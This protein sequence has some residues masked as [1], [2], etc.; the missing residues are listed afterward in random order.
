LA[1][2]VGRE[3]AA[4][5]AG[6]SLRRHRRRLYHST[7]FASCGALRREKD[8]REALRFPALQ[9]R[10]CFYALRS[11]LRSWRE[12]DGPGEH[13]V[14]APPSQRRSQTGSQK[15]NQRRCLRFF[16]PQ[17]LEITK[18]FPDSS[19]LC[20]LDVS[21]RRLDG[22]RIESR[23]S[24]PAAVARRSGHV[25]SRTRTQTTH[26]ASNGPKP[27]GDTI[28]S[29][30]SSKRTRQR[31][32]LDSNVGPHKCTFSFHRIHFPALRRT[33]HMRTNVRA[34]LATHKKVKEI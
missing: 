26:R 22:L 12:C 2:T 6:R 25:R 3:S 27:S 28:K 29:D 32:P 7:A 5:P 24:R 23:T 30:Y 18:G 11:T 16:G 33:R 4:P 10:R 17:D 9:S 20:I 8:R 14:P 1:H 21:K 31:A 19:G 34:C 15:G 13:G